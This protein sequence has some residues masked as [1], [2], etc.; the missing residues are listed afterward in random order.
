MCWII[1]YSGQFDRKTVVLLAATMANT[2][3]HLM[4]DQR[5]IDAVD[6]A[7]R[8]GRGEAAEEDLSNA[9]LAAEAAAAEA[10]ADAAEAAWADA[11]ARAADAAAAEAAARAAAW[12]ARA[13]ARAEAARAARA[14]W[15]EANKRNADIVRELM[16]NPALVF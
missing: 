10:E 6:T 7:I 3:R 14:A 9:A 16:P 15:A 11:A 12:A 1:Q 2:V 13:E 8:Y 4:K 5:S